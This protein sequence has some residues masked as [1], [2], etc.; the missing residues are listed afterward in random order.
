MVQYLVKASKAYWILY[1]EATLFRYVALD[2]ISDKQVTV[3]L[4]ANL[5]EYI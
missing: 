5:R 1:L 2:E 4:F 3:S